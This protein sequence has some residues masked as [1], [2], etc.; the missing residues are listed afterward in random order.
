MTWD[1]QS[2]PPPQ[3]DLTSLPP[4][5]TGPKRVVRKGVRQAILKQAEIE[6]RR[7]PDLPGKHLYLRKADWHSWEYVN[8]SVDRV[9]M[10]CENSASTRFPKSVSCQ[11]RTYEWRRVGKR[12]FMQNARVRDLINVQTGSPV[13]RRTGRH[14][15]GRAGTRIVTPGSEI[16]FPV[17]GRRRSA[18]MSAIDGSGN[19]LIEYRSITRDSKLT[20]E[21][22]IN[23]EFLTVPAIHLIVAVSSRLIFDFFQ[24][25]GGG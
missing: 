6:W 14:F 25:G 13:L 23:P 8:Y 17:K 7:F 1:S 21:I 20:S 9:E 2:L 11:G 12:K 15:E 22:V 24:T 3:P 10:R 5:P 19:R 4:P 16:S 18:V